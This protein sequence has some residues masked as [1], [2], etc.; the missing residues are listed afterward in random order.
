[1][2]PRTFRTLVSRL[3]DETLILKVRHASILFPRSFEWNLGGRSGW[4]CVP[5]RVRGMHLCGRR[6]AWPSGGSPSSQ[7]YTRDH[8]YLQRHRSVDVVRA[9]IVVERHDRHI[10]K[11]AEREALVSRFGGDAPG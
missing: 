10:A 8:E 6:Y 11:R 7:K 3:S 5:K 2:R 1:M 4:L 9:S